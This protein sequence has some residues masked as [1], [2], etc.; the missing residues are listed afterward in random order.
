VR[1]ECINVATHKEGVLALLRGYSASD[2][3]SDTLRVDSI[4][5]LS[6]RG[7]LVLLNAAA[8]ADYYP[9]VKE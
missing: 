7:G 8:A 1:I 9:D 5:E 3:P 2:K 4:Y 6:Q